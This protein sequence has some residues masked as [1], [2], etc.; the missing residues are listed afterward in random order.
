MAYLIA[1]PELIAAAAT[2]LAS[3]G[4]NLNAAHLRAAAPTVAVI[5]AAA[6]EV[7]AAIASVFADRAQAFQGLAGQAAAFSDQFVQTLKSGGASYAATEATSAASLRSIA[8]AAASDPFGGVL[9][10]LSEIGNLFTNAVFF[11]GFLGIAA[12]I[13]FFSVFVAAVLT[14]GA[15]LIPGAQISGYVSFS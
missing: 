4:S 11:L 10:L 12:L 1:D 6:D 7:S 2:D 3:I 9:S 8:A 15:L 13:I 14:L 5:P